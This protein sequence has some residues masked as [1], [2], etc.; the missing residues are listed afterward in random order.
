MKVGD[1]V[2][3]RDDVDSVWGGPFVLVAYET[4]RV[5]EY[6]VASPLLGGV[7]G[8][9]QCRL[10]TAEEIMEF[11]E[12]PEHTGEELPPMKL[13]DL[14]MVRDK[15]DTKWHG[16]YILMNFSANKDFPYRTGAGLYR[17]CRLATEEEKRLV[18][19]IPQRVE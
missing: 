11:D 3:C 2:M 4:R 1:W 17:Y 6:R 7:F 18:E 9:H 5:G 15:T 16:P 13:G 10:A 14:V 19:N 8:Y 12:I